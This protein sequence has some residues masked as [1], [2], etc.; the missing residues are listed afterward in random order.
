MGTV[1]EIKAAIQNLPAEDQARLADWVVERFEKDW[2]RRIA[3]DI[4]AGRL[5]SLLEGAG[6][7]VFIVARRAHALRQAQDGG[8]VSLS[9]GAHAQERGEAR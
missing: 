7:A 4:E 6:R 9:N 3:A 1:D 5:D 8:V 2:D